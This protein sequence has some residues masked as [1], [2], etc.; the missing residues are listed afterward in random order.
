FRVADVA[1]GAA[2]TTPRTTFDNLRAAKSSP[3]YGP[4]LRGSTIGTIA[5]GSLRGVYA[6]GADGSGVIGSLGFR[7]DVGDGNQFNGTWGGNRSSPAIADIDGDGAYEMIIGIEGNQS[8]GIAA[9]GGS[10][11][12]L[13]W[14]VPIPP[15]VVNPP[16]NAP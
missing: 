12:Y 16:V 1:T 7:V 3:S 2:G 15:R 13:K 11:P 14:R 10:P 5:G 4:L 8:P 6:L 9:Y